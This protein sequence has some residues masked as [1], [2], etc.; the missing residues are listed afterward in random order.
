MPCGR[1]GR[2][3][4]IVLGPAVL[5]GVQGCSQGVP[6][7]DL[8]GWVRSSYVT[9]HPDAATAPY[10]TWQAALRRPG[11]TTLVQAVQDGCGQ[12]ESGGGGEP[13]TDSGVTCGRDAF[14][15]APDGVDA[16]SRS[17]SGP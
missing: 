5:A 15:W 12:N 16:P 1:P 10:G 9:Q 11:L 13:V 14:V 17:S 3:R 4:G 7:V 6:G 8:G 2:W